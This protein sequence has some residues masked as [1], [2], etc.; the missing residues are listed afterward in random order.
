M[1]YFIISLSII[2]ADQ[3]TK[4]IVI[5]LVAYQSMI[6]V[7]ES[8][9]YIT[10]IRNSGAAWGLFP[11][12]RLFLILITLSIAIFIIYFI[13]KSDIKFL[14][15]SLGIILGGAVGNLIDRALYGSVV[16]F[17]DFYI[18]SYHFPTFNIADSFVVIGTALLAY[19]L[20]FVY[21]DK[22]IRGF[23]FKEEKE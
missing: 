21:K 12:G 19:Y 2:A 18:G 6:P 13:I 11:N 20:I 5:K 9:F 14:N 1:L 7:V 3:I 4:Y 15:L 10:N 16:D 22:D 17:L 8:F 23:T